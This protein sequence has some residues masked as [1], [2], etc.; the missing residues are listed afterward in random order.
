MPLE[1]I[2][3]FYPCVYYWHDSMLSEQPKV[4]TWV[5]ARKMKQDNGTKHVTNCIKKSRLMEGWPLQNAFNLE[6]VDELFPM[7]LL[8]NK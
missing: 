4:K 1:L 3:Y 5:F 8:P 7:S 2:G 6:L